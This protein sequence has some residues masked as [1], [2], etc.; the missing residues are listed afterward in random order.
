MYFTCSISTPDA[1]F[2]NVSFAVYP[3]IFPGLPFHVVPLVPYFFHDVYQFQSHGARFTN[4]KIVLKSYFPPKCGLTM[5][6][7]FYK[8]SDKKN[9][10]FSCPIRGSGCKKD[11]YL[12]YWTCND[13]KMFNGRRYKFKREFSTG[14]RKQRHFY[15][16]E[17]SSSPP[18]HVFLLSL[19]P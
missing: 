15:L 8:L 19:C 5:G 17:T 4:V 10:P 2:L 9:W 6:S 16:P 11:R 18:C 3:N 14:N 13:I 12:H 1:P 7:S